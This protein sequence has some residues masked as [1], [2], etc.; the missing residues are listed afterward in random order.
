MKK[1]FLLFAFTAPF[2]SNAQTIIAVPNDTVETWNSVNDWVSDYIYVQN[3]GA[4]SLNVSFTVMTNTMD[5][6]GWDV[7]LCT[8]NGCFS[9]VPTSGS[10]GDIAA[11]DSGHLNLHG[12]FVGIPGTGVVRIR[13]YETGN[14]TNQAI[15]VFKY[16]AAVPSAVA[17]IG[18][19][20][21]YLSGNFPNP[22]TGSAQ[23]NYSLPS[24]GGTL[25]VVDLSGKILSSA[26]L[27]STEGT[28]DVGE[29]LGSGI[30]FCILSDEN[31]NL[32]AVRR[33]VKQ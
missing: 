14:A 5:P 8:S 16:H 10:L 4:A 25:S 3:T 17:G 30:Y 18:T 12:G 9:Y 19:Q 33:I 2:F 13:V 27:T 28:I 7:L 20:E 23:L 11:G 24:A 29:N 15:I 6:L 1:I 26:T 21:N 22:F 32:L 31:K